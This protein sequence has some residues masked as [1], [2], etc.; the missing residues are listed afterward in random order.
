MPEN[1]ESSTESEEALA[2]QENSFAESEAS[3]IET[4]EPIAEFNQTIDDFEMAYDDS[5]TLIDL[6]L[7]EADP[8]QPRKHF[9]EEEIKSLAK[10]ID[11]YG[12]IQSITVRK[13]GD[14]YIVVD[15]ERRLRAFRILHDYKPVKYS[16]IPVSI[17][18]VSD[19]AEPKTLSLLANVKRE[20][21]LPIER[22]EALWA[23]KEAYEKI[24][25][26]KLTQEK[27]GEALTLKQTS[28]SKIM[29]LVKLAPEIKDVIRKSSDYPLKPLADIATKRDLN[30]QKELFNKLQDNLKIQ[31]T[32]FGIVPTSDEK[33]TNSSKL[34]FARLAGDI[35]ALSTTSDQDFSDNKPQ[36]AAA[37]LSAFECLEKLAI[38]S[39]EFPFDL[40][41]E[42][43]L[44]NLKAELETYIPTS[45][46][47]KK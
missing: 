31:R 45:S 26:K 11:R 15:G 33:P 7:I 44:E 18:N 28:V 19:K 23:Y 22:A 35:K 4:K 46:K 43:S 16:S 27:L 17:I 41:K 24:N 21:L 39:E 29:S 20:D 10:N 30:K 5:T 12:L 37:I 25:K 14:K 40:S 9:D 32:D 42:V 3:S 6:D 47:N 8:N 34:L 1:Q 2:E 36:V 38:L 13:S